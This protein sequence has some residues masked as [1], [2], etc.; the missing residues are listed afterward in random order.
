VAFRNSR[1]L[2]PIQML[3]WGSGGRR[4][5]SGRPDQ[6]GT[7]GGR[8]FSSPEL[9]SSNLTAPAA[10]ILRASGVKVDHQ[11]DTGFALRI[12]SNSF[13]QSQVPRTLMQPI[14]RAKSNGQ[15]VQRNVKSFRGL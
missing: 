3:E 4:F 8:G 6:L 1:S 9:V 5:K 13:D 11:G 7:T 14:S 12:A 2:P 10:T 15:Q